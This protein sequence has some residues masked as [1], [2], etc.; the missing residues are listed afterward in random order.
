MTEDDQIHHS[1]LAPFSHFRLIGD[2]GTNL[3]P[4][5]FW[6]TLAIVVALKRDFGSRPFECDLVQQVE[7]G[8]EVLL[9]NYQN[10]IGGID[11]SEVIEVYLE[12]R[13][14]IEVGPKAW[15]M[16]YGFSDPEETVSIFAYWTTF[17]EAIYMR[18]ENCSTVG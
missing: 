9:V 12:G 2:S 16:K 4:R 6:Q 15:M 8:S 7:P 11:M 10:E 18:P 17:M 14:Y 1:D 5:E 3:T 13:I